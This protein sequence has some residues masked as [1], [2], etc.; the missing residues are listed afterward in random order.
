MELKSVLVYMMV[1]EGNNV[2][3]YLM[4]ETSPAFEDT[5]HDI[6]KIHSKDA[7]VYFADVKEVESNKYPQTKII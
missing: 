5:C 2:F 4:N 1:E 3:K 6:L 7:L